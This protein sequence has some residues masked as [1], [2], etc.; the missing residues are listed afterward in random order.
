MQF[1]GE[2]VFMLD[3]CRQFGVRQCRK[4]WNFRSCSAVMVVD[5]PVMQFIDG[6]GCPCVFAGTV[7]LWLE[8]PQTQ[9]IAG[10]HGLSSCRVWVSSWADG[11][12]ELGAHHTGDELN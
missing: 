12:E 2:A 6:C 7:G 1:L 4:L 9:F 3:A 5:V 8:V 11:D 10:V